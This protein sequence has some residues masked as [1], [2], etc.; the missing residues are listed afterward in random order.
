[1]HNGCNRRFFNENLMYGFYIY[2]LLKNIVEIFAYKNFLFLLHYALILTII[3]KTKRKHAL[4]RYSI[5]HITA[6]FFAE[7]SFVSIIN[8]TTVHFL[9][10]VFQMIQNGRW[11]L[12][13]LDLKKGRNIVSESFRSSEFDAVSSG[14]LLPSLL[15]FAKRFL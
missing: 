5:Y 6:S 14:T 13:I 9:I 3:N 2:I 7:E 4:N 10:F 8:R 11:R 15:L 1:M 12:S